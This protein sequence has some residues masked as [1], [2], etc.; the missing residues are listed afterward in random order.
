MLPLLLVALAV[1]YATLEAGVGASGSSGT[2]PSYATDAPVTNARAGDDGWVRVAP[3]D[4][5]AQARVGVEY[6]TLARVI[7]SEM[8]NGSPLEKTA[9][10]WAIVNEARRRGWSLLRLATNTSRHGDLG[11]YGS[12]EHGRYMS[13]ARDPSSRAVYIATM[14]L[15]GHW[16]DPTGGANQFFNPEVQRRKHAQYPCPNVRNARGACYD[17][18][19]VIAQRWSAGGREVVV[20]AGTRQDQLWFVRD[21]AA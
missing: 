11:L 12:Q 9:I 21:R 18:P 10:G 5:A 14:I 16:G 15:D 13:T 1:Y 4:L 20:L 3:R 17:P 2:F 19:E 8:A 7:D 6:Y